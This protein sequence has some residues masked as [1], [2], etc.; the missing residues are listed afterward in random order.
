MEEFSVKEWK[1]A[2]WNDFGNIWKY[3]YMK[4]GAQGQ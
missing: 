1:K 3:D 4:A 2:A